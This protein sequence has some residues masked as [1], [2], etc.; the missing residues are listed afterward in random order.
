MTHSLKDHLSPKL[1]SL[2]DR[3]MNST[4][5]MLQ[6]SVQNDKVKFNVK[7]SCVLSTVVE[8]Y[9]T[10]LILYHILRNKKYRLPYKF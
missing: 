1:H 10:F 8:R 2:K 7:P 3:I 5:S 9:G 4:D 6:D